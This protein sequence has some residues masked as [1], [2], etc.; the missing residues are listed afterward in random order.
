MNLQHLRLLPSSKVVAM[1]SL[2]VDGSGR[3][4][5]AFYVVQP[6]EGEDGYV[7]MAADE[8]QQTVLGYSPTGHFDAERLNDTER[9]WLTH[10][11]IE[12]RG[13][14]RAAANETDNAVKMLNL[15]P[16]RPEGV[17]PLTTVKWSQH[18]PFNN[19]CPNPQD[20]D[21]PCVTGCVATAMAQVMK[22]YHSST[23]GK[24][25]HSYTTEKL[26]LPLSANY[27]GVTYDWNTM[28]DDYSNGYTQ[29]QADAVA[30]LMLHCGVAVDMNY[31]YGGSGA[32][33]QKMVSALQ[34]Y[35][36]YDRDMIDVSTKSGVDVVWHRRA[37]HELNEDRLVVYATMNH[38][39]LLDG[40]EVQEG[41]DAP[42]Y[43]MNMGWGGLDNAYY[44]LSA[45]TALD[46]SSLDHEMIIGVQPEDNQCRAQFSVSPNGFPKQV[47]KGVTQAYN[48]QIILSF[49]SWD[50]YDDYASMTGQLELVAYRQDGQ[51]TTVGKWPVENLSGSLFKVQASIDLDA[52]LSIG[53]YALEWR[54]YADGDAAGHYA[55][56]STT[57]ANSL[58]VYQQVPQLTA[59]MVSKDPVIEG[60]D[61]QITFVVTNR[62]QETYYG[63]LTERMQNEAGA[64]CEFTSDFMILPPDQ[65]VEWTFGGMISNLPG[66]PAT[67][68]LLDSY[69]QNPIS[70]EQG[71]P[72]E[73]ETETQPLLPRLQY[74]NISLSGNY[75]NLNGFNENVYPFDGSLAVAVV[76]DYDNVLEVLW[77]L[78]DH[79]I[80]KGFLT[81]YGSPLV[82][83]AIARNNVYTGY[84]PD[85]EYKV[86][87]AVRQK[88]SGQW[89]AFTCCRAHPRDCVPLTLSGT[90]GVVG[91][92]ASG[93][94]ALT[95]T[96]WSGQ[97]GY[98]NVLVKRSGVGRLIHNSEPLFAQENHRICLHDESFALRVIVPQG[99]RVTV[100]CDGQDV[101][102]EIKDE[103]L[104]LNHVT[105]DHEL[106]V[107]FEEVT[108]D[109]NGDAT[110]SVSDLTTTVEL[111][112]GNM[113]EGYCYAGADANHDGKLDRLDVETVANAI[114]NNAEA[115][116]TNEHQYVDLGLEGFPNLRWATCNL[117]AEHPFE[118]GDFYSWGEICPKL[119]YGEGQYTLYEDGDKTKVM[120]YNATDHLTH[121][122]PEDD[123]AHMQWGGDWRMPR[124][125]ETRALAEQCTLKHYY[126]SD[127]PYGGVDGYELTG[128]NGNKI[129][130]PS[131]DFLTVPDYWG[132][133]RC[134][135]TSDLYSD[136]VAYL[137]TITNFFFISMSGGG[138]SNRDSGAIIR[139]VCEVR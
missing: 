110:L 117:G 96:A 122:L 13:M 127:S 118:V 12:M 132:L 2:C 107:R 133:S 67:Y 18:A 98:H 61:H 80:P 134:M 120:K 25:S 121:L 53:Y 130:L 55:L 63:A 39:F 29:A 50:K 31:N 43:H 7:I 70:D 9:E 41:A 116:Q 36:G 35:Y 129:F 138:T 38:C 119:G 58:I 45:I 62:G 86:K 137:A 32:V 125:E 104:R 44:L 126:A 74:W 101:T 60:E 64:K 4:Q 112:R 37:L 99:H 48:G 19:M 1:D 128:P 91:N 20:R 5:E 94:I 106:E 14:R 131:H 21:E 73:F 97:V 40:Y 113:P 108:G 3:R 139:P 15:L 123:A 34:N 82:Y 83:A 65:S 46:V 81:T 22:H 33:T 71:S 85:G 89:H 47:Q 59:Q 56:A 100:L 79:S 68:S 72:L 49:L 42:Y 114:V 6:G 54:Y 88:N 76:D 75:A 111:V 11:A 115:L 124:V 30:Q 78:F 51:Q 77:T 17:E 26:K 69:L 136:Q 93:K 24:G 109:A 23:P 87:M 102:A 10:Y 57:S 95:R 90:T 66:G 8:R 16:V 92:E 52:K 105:T 84:L 28:L 103:V 135:W 27:E